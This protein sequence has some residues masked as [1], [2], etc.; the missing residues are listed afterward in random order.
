MRSIPDPIPHQDLDTI[1]MYH[2]ISIIY[3]FGIKLELYSPGS[4]VKIR[5]KLQNNYEVAELWSFR[6]IFRYVDL[7]IRRFQK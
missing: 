7:K 4:T 3:E 5:L 6:E 1:V 2:P